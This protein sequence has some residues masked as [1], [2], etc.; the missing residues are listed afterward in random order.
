[1]AIYHQSQIPNLQNRTIKS[2]I[3]QKKFSKRYASRCG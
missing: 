3:L 1:M 2:S